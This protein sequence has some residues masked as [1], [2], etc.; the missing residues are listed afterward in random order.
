MS[1][2]L[3]TPMHAIMNYANLCKKTD[4]LKS[5]D[6]ILKYM[7]NI[8][9][10][11][12]R[13]LVLIN[14]LLDLA[15]I[16]SGKMEFKFAKPDIMNVVNQVRMEIDPIFKQKNINFIVNKLSEN[17]EAEF[18]NVRMVQVLINLLLNAVKFS[19]KDGST[20]TFASAENS[21]RHTSKRFEVVELLV[22]SL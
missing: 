19:D 11:G 14:N 6:K 5:S 22:M 21:I 13:L 8:Q 18:D 15:K 2:E 12:N 17:S 10:A 1:H 16:E 9:V 7:D 4:V 20:N 3:R